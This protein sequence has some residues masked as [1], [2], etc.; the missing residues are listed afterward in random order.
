MSEIGNEDDYR[1]IV[2][3]RI[4]RVSSTNRAAASDSTKA[5][6]SYVV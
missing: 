1:T 6:I 5:M 2:N 4:V 3:A